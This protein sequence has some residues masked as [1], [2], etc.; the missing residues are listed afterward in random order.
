MSDVMKR[1]GLVL[2]MGE[3]EYHGFG[4]FEELRTAEFSSSA[5][6]AILNTPADYEWEYLK[7]KPKAPTEAMILGTAV[8]T[9]V[10]G[11]GAEV[12]KVPEEWV[13]KNGAISSK[14][15][16]VE[17]VAKQEE[18]GLTVLTPAKFERVQGMTEA[19]LAH[20]LASSWFALEGHSEASVFA[21]DPETGV[22]LR[23]RFDYLPDDPRA[24]L[25]LKTTADASPRGFMKRAHDLKY[26]VSRAHYL[27][28]AELAGIPRQEMVFVVVENTAPFKVAVYQFNREQVER[29]ENEARKARRL[30]ARCLETNTW[31]GYS[32]ELEFLEA[33]AYAMYQDEMESL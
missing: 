12:V 26:H 2:G 3:D 18:A 32:T 7:S 24:S 30:L 5:A 19:V 20:P 1:D 14:R 4:E 8:H 27:H 17:W 33:P 29:G 28:T 21:T 9:R 25:D 11:V 23:C 13:L 6:K 10:L 16:A 22:R 31:P 15:E